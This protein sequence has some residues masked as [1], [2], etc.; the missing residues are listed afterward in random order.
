MKKLSLASVFFVLGAPLLAQAQPVAPVSAPQ[1]SAVTSVEDWKGADPTHE[2]M[3][4]AMSGL[5]VINSSAGFG[6]VGAISKKIVNHGFVPDISNQVYIEA[7]MGPVF[8]NSANPFWFST[9]LRWD[10]HK[11]SNWSLFALGGTTGQIVGTGAG[12]SQF[13][14][15]LRTGIGAFYHINEQLS[16]RG[17]LSH[18]FTGLG[19]S[20]S[21]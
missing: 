11:D 19:V 7:E 1:V 8:S 10:F 14:L 12:S 6:L 4:S 16:V 18:E 21:L 3:F 9:H 15:F 13:N 17:E 5:G 20:W 2:V